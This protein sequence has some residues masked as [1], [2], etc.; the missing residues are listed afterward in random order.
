MHSDACFRRSLRWD[1]SSGRPG[2]V[3]DDLRPPSFFLF[4]VINSP[5]LQLARNPHPGGLGWL[6]ACNPSRVAFASPAPSAPLAGERGVLLTKG[7]AQAWQGGTAVALL[8]MLACELAAD[9]G[10][11]LG[12]VDRQGKA[13]AVI[14]GPMWQR[15]VEGVSG[16]CA[17]Q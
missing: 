1:Q 17:L 4:F 12:C 6:L 16:A 14:M 11:L 5:W 15:Q 9:L 8:A 13:K 3:H 10:L 7:T 2:F